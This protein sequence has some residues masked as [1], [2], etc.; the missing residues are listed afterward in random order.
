ML[1]FLKLTAGVAMFHSGVAQTPAQ[2]AQALLAKMSL[3]DK[4]NMLHGVSSPGYTGSTAPNPAL[5]IP[6]LTLNDGR[7][8]R[9]LLA[10]ARLLPMS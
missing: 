4:V 8:V 5:G 9:C 2:R 7:Q 3:T 10:F 1:K 6:S